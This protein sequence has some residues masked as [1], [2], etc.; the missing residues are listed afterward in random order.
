MFTFFHFCAWAGLL[1]HQRCFNTST[2]ASSTTSITLDKPIKYYIFLH[3]GIPR[4]IQS[5]IL[6]K[7]YDPSP[8]A[9]TSTKFHNQDAANSFLRVLLTWAQRIWA[10]SAQP[11]RFL[12]EP[13]FPGFPYISPPPPPRLTKYHCTRQHC[14]LVTRNPSPT[15][16][17][18][19]DQKR[20]LRTV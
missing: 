11:A 4:Y 12:L 18:S 17:K 14:Y 5:D 9:M 15:A 7:F 16:Q 20:N 2:I 10:R 3:C 8:S 1:Y 13:V 6:D 19:W